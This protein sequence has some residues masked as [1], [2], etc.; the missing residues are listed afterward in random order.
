MKSNGRRGKSGQIGRYLYV[1]GNVALGSAELPSAVY[2][3]G[4][5]VLESGSDS[6]P[7]QISYAEG[8]RWRESEMAS[9]LLVERWV[10]VATS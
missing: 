3:I 1:S 6:S 8:W 9:I 10:V 2:L 5:C 4:H 7:M